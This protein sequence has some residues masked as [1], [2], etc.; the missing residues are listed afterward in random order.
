MMLFHKSTVLAVV[1]STDDKTSTKIA[2]GHEHLELF[3]R[4]V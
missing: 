3:S 4:G 1:E 2:V